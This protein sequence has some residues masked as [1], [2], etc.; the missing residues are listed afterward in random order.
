M[1]NLAA[2][3][4]HRNGLMYD[5]LDPDYPTPLDASMA[6]LA[7]RGKAIRDSFAWLG[8]GGRTGDRKRAEQMLHYAIE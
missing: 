1:A 6:Q 7:R 3:T 4:S 2:E 8:V 5:F